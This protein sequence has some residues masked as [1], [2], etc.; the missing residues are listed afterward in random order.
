MSIDQIGIIFTGVIAVWL[1]QD[2][3]QSWRRWA[4]IFGMVG[5]PF[6]FYAAYNAAQWGVFIVCFLYT[7][8]WAR[9][10]WTNWLA[11]GTADARS[12]VK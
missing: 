5:Q 6:W 1:T 7:L 11:T 10:I 2:K 8:S 9:G 4:C 3:R 12:A